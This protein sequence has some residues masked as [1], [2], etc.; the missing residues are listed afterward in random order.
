[1]KEPDKYRGVN[2]RFGMK[3]VI[4]APHYDSRRN[5]IAMIR[6]R[7]RYII[8]PPRECNKLQLYPRGHPSA[9]HSQIRWSDIE[10]V[11]KYP[12]LYNADAFEV[13]NSQ[14]D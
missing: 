3:G 12:D 13:R 2:C 8:L 14:S 11:K 5:Y 10:E 7:K 6:G 9:R 1:M 4:A